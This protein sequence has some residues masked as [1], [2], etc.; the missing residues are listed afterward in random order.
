MLSCWLTYNQLT[1]IN[2]RSGGEKSKR[3]SLVHIF[4][5]IKKKTCWCVIPVLSVGQRVTTSVHLRAIFNYRCSVYNV[6]SLQVMSIVSDSITLVRFC[7]IYS[8]HYYKTNKMG[9]K[10]FLL[11]EWHRARECPAW[12]SCKTNLKDE[13]VN[14]V[15]LS[16]I[17]IAAA[18]LW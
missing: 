8:C 9:Y 2:C 13:Y 11:S 6:V 16:M 3:T 10:R 4:Q 1:S 12:L 7:S 14:I 5:V 15:I 17:S 18:N